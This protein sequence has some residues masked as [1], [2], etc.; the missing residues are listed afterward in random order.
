MI[1][2]LHYNTYTVYSLLAGIVNDCPD[3]GID[4][5]HINDC[6]DVINL[7]QE[8]KVRASI[9]PDRETSMQHSSYQQ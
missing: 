1:H 8:W 7:M 6:V 3:D 5:I 4:N 2:H 9:I